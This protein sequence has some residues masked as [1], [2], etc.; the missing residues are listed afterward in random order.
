MLLLV[1]F[2]QLMQHLESIRESPWPLLESALHCS[3]CAPDGVA[4]AL[5]HALVRP[6]TSPTHRWSLQL[7][8]TSLLSLVVLLWWQDICETR[9]MQSPTEYYKVHM[10][11]VV[12]VHKLCGPCNYW[13]GCYQWLTAPRVMIEAEWVS[14]FYIP[15]ISA[16]HLYSSL[17]FHLSLRCFHSLHISL[18]SLPSFACR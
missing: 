9:T 6:R 16:R 8:L 11:V 1:G 4:K 13:W 18:I 17:S 5:S 10:S 15:L 2:T 12:T 7:L 14:R 3:K